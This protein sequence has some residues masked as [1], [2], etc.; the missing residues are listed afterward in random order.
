MNPY[1]PFQWTNGGPYQ[2]APHQY[3]ATAAATTAAAAAAVNNAF[4]GYAL[5]PFMMPGVAS[6]PP[7]VTTPS[8]PQEK[9]QI[10]AWIA[11]LGQP[12]KR[13]HAL[14]ELTKKRDAIPELAPL[15][16][17][18]FGT[19][20]ALLQEVVSVYGT[21]TPPTLTPHRSNRVCS[22]LSLL[23]VV[24]SHP[25]TRSGFLRAHLLLF[26]YPFLQSTVN[27]KPFEYLRLTSL[28]VIG[29]LLKTEDP[30]V[31]PFLLT[32]EIIPLCLRNM[33]TG[34]ELSRTV[35]TY[36]LQKIL[37]HENGL[38]FACQTYERFSHV[39]LILGKMVHHL[40]KH[41]APRLLKHVIRCYLRLTEN[42]RAK[43]ALGQCL[44]GPL[45]D[46]TFAEQI[47]DDPSTKRLLVHL[48]KNL[49]PNAA[50][51]A[52][53]QPAGH[54]NPETWQPQPSAQ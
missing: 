20:S 43:D 2:G 12:D 40:V 17:H 49:E 54:L 29:A 8:T 16:W 21:M 11:D 18:S 4:M 23:Q 22:A 27:K 9:A 33:E 5:P 31:I 30:E 3:P 36:I 24:A 15:I 26:L 6:Q 51:V 25:D 46:Q 50:S 45:K 10:Y 19:I 47:K 37:T 38:A 32:T 41:P 44:P 53:S 52:A 35:A 7:P 48:L 14:T 34:E 42:P 39:A 13:E 28:G 1:P